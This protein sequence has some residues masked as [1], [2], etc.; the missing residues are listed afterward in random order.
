MHQCN[1]ER[2]RKK[3]YPKKQQETFTF[4]T[5]TDIRIQIQLDF[6][7]VN[8][9]SFVCCFFCV[10]VLCTLGIKRCMDHS[11]LLYDRAKLLFL[12][13]FLIAVLRAAFFSLL[14]Y[15]YINAREYNN[16]KNST[17][18]SCSTS[19]WSAQSPNPNEMISYTYVYRTLTQN[20]ARIKFISVLLYFIIV[21]NTIAPI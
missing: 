9:S 4:K 13:F 17:M 21:V 14:V 16:N 5:D 18:I 8:L 20:T 11:I 19:K 10:Y 6:V 3:H 12:L 7:S 2:E 1:F 15:D